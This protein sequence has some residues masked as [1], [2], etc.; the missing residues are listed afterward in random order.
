M[1]KIT[2]KLCIVLACSLLIGCVSPIEMKAETSTIQLDTMY[3][4][5]IKYSIDLNLQ[6]GDV[7]IAGKIKNDFVRMSLD[8]EGEAEIVIKNKN[9]VEEYYATIENLTNEGDVDIKVYDD[10]EEDEEDIVCEFD[11]YD[12]LIE[13]DYDEQVPIAIP[14][15]VTVADVAGTLFTIYLAYEAV[16]VINNVSYISLQKYYHSVTVEKADTE[17]EEKAKKYYYPAKITKQHNT[18]IWPKGIEKKEAA[19]L[20]SKDWNIYTFEKRMAKSVVKAAG[21]VA[22]NSKGYQVAEIHKG[23]R[24]KG[25]YVYYHYHRGKQ[26]SSG[27]LKKDGSSHVLFGKPYYV[28]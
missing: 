21:Y 13:D 12:D 8:Q 5:G 9:Y 6:T 2:R 25:H 10:E 28:S 3:A 16:Q 27:K 19:K 20:V 11:E 18:Y 17:V 22:I 24:L 23:E 4:D 14:I 7:I 26:N 15:A 1:K